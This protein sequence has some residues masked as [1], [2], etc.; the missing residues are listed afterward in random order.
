MKGGIIQ[1]DGGILQAK[2]IYYLIALN[3]TEKFAHFFSKLANEE[4]FIYKNKM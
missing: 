3:P 4:R 1:I 2:E